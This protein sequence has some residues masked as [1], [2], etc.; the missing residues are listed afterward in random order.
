MFDTQRLYDELEWMSQRRIEYIFATDANFGI[1]VRDQDIARKIADLKMTTGYPRY[2][3]VNWTKNSSTKVIKAAGTKGGW[4]VK[5]NA[6]GVPLY[7][8]RFGW[9]LFQVPGEPLC[10]L[11]TFYISEEYVG[12]KPKKDKDV[13]FARLRWQKCR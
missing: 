11:R 7:R 3:M 4:S 12:R 5:K 10:Q 8:D 9:I 13:G 6:L 2:F 1:K